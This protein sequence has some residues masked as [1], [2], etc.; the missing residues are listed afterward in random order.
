[1]E[2]TS[3]NVMSLNAFSASVFSKVPSTVVFRI[4]LL[5][6]TV[7][8]RSRFRLLVGTSVSPSF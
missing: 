1:M 5:S 7:L 4:E 3:T 8:W 6:S 2:G